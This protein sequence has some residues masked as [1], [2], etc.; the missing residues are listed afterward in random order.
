MPV[1]RSFARQLQTFNNLGLE[2]ENIDIA[3]VHGWFVFE[4]ETQKIINEC[5]K[6]KQ[7]ILMHIPNDELDSYFNRIDEIKKHFPNVTIFRNSL[8]N[9]HFK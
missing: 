9:K 8:E 1:V 7:V 4:P 3:S 2:K 6:P 5:L